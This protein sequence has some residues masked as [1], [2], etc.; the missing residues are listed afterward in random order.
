MT[1]LTAT[2]RPEASMVR[3]AL[4]CGQTA[5]TNHAGSKHAGSNRDWNG[6]PALAG[7]HI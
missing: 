2:Y 7:G 4:P 3:F 1:L 5:R 6:S